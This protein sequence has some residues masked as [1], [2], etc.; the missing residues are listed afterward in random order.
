MLILSRPVPA[1]GEETVGKTHALI[2][3]L[4]LILARYLADAITAITPMEAEE[5]RRLANMPREK[6]FVVSSP[7][8]EAFCEYK[9]PSDAN[10]IR[11]K[12]GMNLLIDKKVVLYHGE[13]EEN[14]AV[15]EVA[16]EFTKAFTDRNDIVLLFVGPGSARRPLEMRVRRNELRNCAV[17]GPVP[18]SAMPGL[19]KSCDL[20][21]VILPDRPWWQNQCPTKLLEFLVMNKPVVATDLPGIRWAARDSP[22]VTYV[23]GFK[24]EELRTAITK[25][26]AIHGAARNLDSERL[27]MF[28]SGRLAG[29]LDLIIRGQALV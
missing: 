5:F 17:M 8:S 1:V 22:L 16:R 24:A 10:V 15:T 29:K 13:M 14:R 3:R 21:L 2:F 18:Y 27:Q 4:S 7:V 9:R 11:R 23:K 26:L 25:A 28:A 20:G 19:I 6:V 12:L